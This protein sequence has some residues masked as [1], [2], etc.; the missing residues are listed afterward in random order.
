VLSS[1]LEEEQYLAK[2]F[3][4][5]QGLADSISYLSQGESFLKEQIKESYSSDIQVELKPLSEN[6][7]AFIQDVLKFNLEKNTDLLIVLAERKQTELERYYEHSISRQLIRKS[8]CSLLLISN[9]TNIFYQKALVE[10]STHPKNRST[11]VMAEFVS[12]A[13]GIQDIKTIPDQLNSLN[14]NRNDS[15][16]AKS[17]AYPMEQGYSIAEMVRSSGSDLLIISSPDTKLGFAD[18]VFSDAFEYLISEPPSDILIVHS[19]KKLPLSPI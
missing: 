4:L 3:E 19:T 7:D 10:R 8:Y 13:I 5:A 6:S 1:G 16:K 18:R 9:L 14:A 12:E 2:T 15:K 17:I 11:H